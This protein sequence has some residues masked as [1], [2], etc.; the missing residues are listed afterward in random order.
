[1]LALHNLSMVHQEKRRPF[2]ENYAILS[3]LSHAISYPCL[4]GKIILEEALIFLIRYTE[5]SSCQVAK[6]GYTECRKIER[7][8]KGLISEVRGGWSLMKRTQ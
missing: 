6:A 1:M 3:T 8:K 7:E 2:N 4:T 5:L